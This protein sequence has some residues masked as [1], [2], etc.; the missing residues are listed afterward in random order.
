[1]A[2][3]CCLAWADSKLGCQSQQ[4]EADWLAQSVRLALC[5]ARRRIDLCAGSAED[6]ADRCRGLLNDAA[7]GERG[8]GSE[9]KDRAAWDE[10]RGVKEEERQRMRAWLKRG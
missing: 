1:M 10:V 6:M 4:R 7:S 3:G 8:L 9:C 5:A 2:V